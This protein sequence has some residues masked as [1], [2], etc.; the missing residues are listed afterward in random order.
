MCV[1]VYRVE[2]MYVRHTKKEHDL[3][4]VCLYVLASIFQKGEIY[5]LPMCDTEYIL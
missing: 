2:Y 3:Q 1:H 4:S 5:N